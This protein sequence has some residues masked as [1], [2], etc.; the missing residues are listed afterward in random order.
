VIR[1]SRTGGDTYRDH[2]WSVSYTLL[3]RDLVVGASKPSTVFEFVP[4][5][6]DEVPVE[7]RG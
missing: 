7:T 1:R 4:Q 5:N 2:E 3:M 6:V